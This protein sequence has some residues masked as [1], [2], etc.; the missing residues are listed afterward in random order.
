MALSW[1]LRSEVETPEVLSFN[2]ISDIEPVNATSQEIRSLVNSSWRWQG[3]DYETML[4]LTMTYQGSTIAKVT[5]AATGRSVILDTTPTLAAST[6]ILDGFASYTEDLQEGWRFMIWGDPTI[7]QLTADA[8]AD[9]S[10]YTVSITP[11][12]TAAAVALGAGS[13][14]YFFLP[15]DVKGKRKS[16]D[17]EL[18]SV[19]INAGFITEFETVNQPEEE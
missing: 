17:Q 16:M 5:A 18:H 12:V 13:A 14:V 4:W 1:D 3:L 2:V 9:S 19:T 11:A 6:M 8:T 10:A 15:G 7:Y